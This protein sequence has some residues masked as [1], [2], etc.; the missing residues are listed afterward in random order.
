MSNKTRNQLFLN[1]LCVVI[2]ENKYNI[3]ISREQKCTFKLQQ[4]HPLMQKIFSLSSNF[5]KIESRLNIWYL[6]R[7]QV[8]RQSAQYVRVVHFKIP[9]YLLIIRC[10]CEKCVMQDDVHDDVLPRRYD[11]AVCVPPLSLIFIS[12]SHYNGNENVCGTLAGKLVYKEI[13]CNILKKQ[14]FNLSRQAG[15]ERVENFVLSL[16]MSVDI[17]AAVWSRL[18]SKFWR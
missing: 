13:I 10:S 12:S 8:D 3:V 11:V 9:L 18:T 5:L 16:Q 14:E 7:D 6:D 15:R 1:F 17:L 4:Q 2:S